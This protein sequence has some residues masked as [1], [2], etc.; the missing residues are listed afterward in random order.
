[1]KKTYSPEVRERAVQMV[2]DHQHK[3]EHAS[4]RAAICSIAAKIGCSG[5]TLRSWVR[6]HERDD[7]PREGMTCDV[8]ERLKAPDRENRELRQAGE[9]LRKASACLAQLGLDAS[10]RT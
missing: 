2:L 3:H 7:G 5:E 6:Q 1:L 4:E 9:V 8:R 10:P